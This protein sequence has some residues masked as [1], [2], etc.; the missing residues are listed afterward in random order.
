M[1]NNNQTSGCKKCKQK[2]PGALQIGS[3]IVGFYILFSSIYGTIEIGKSII[4]W[5]KSSFGI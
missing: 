2:G 5:V 4:S 3:I 1:E